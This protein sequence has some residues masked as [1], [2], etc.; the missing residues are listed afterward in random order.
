M[1]ACAVDVTYGDFLDKG[2]SGLLKYRCAEI[3][4]A[5]INRI[6]EGCSY[7]YKNML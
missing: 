1:Y 5:N 6:P 7:T 2:Q 3:Q 4:K